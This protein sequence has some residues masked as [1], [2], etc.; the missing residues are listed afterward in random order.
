[1]ENNSWAAI[2]DDC[3][4]E[5]FQNWIPHWIA[6]VVAIIYS[7]IWQLPLSSCTPTFCSSLIIFWLSWFSLYFP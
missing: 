1:M 3:W 5:E 2:D 7:N 4:L 6:I